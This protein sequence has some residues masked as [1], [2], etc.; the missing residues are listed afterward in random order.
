MHDPATPGMA[1]FDPVD[2]KPVTIVFGTSDYRATVRAWIALAS[3]GAC[4]HW[5]IVC[6]DEGLA[7]W[8]REGGWAAHAVDYYAVLPNAPRADFAALP[9]AARMAALWAART[10]LFLHLAEAGRDFI[11]SDA[12]AFWYRDPRPWLAAHPAFDLVFSQGA[13]FPR[14]HH[15]RHLFVVCAGFFLCRANAR[16]AAYFRRV[17][18]LAAADP[19]DQSRMNRVLLH[20]RGGR[21]MVENARLRVRCA[22]GRW[23]APIGVERLPLVLRVRWLVARLG[24]RAG[25]SRRW[26]RRFVHIRVSEEPIR[27]RFGDGLAVAVMPMHLVVRSGAVPSC[28][29]YVVHHPANR[30]APADGAAG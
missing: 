16:S 14:R 7:A 15:D 20:D 1:A 3:R 29:A 4:D 2:G 19:D 27:G 8:L 21:W 25:A 13:A 17:E 23:R 10:R 5:R 6:M 11:H 22:P 30:I 18:A 12:D 24:G 9:R 26:Q 28:G